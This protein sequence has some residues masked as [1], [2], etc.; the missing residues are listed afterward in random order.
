[1]ATSHGSM[2]LLPKGHEDIKFFLFFVFC[3]WILA[4]VEV[5]TSLVPVY[6]AAQVKCQVQ[7][8]R[9]D[10]CVMIGFQVSN[11]E[12]KLLDVEFA[13]SPTQHS[14][15]FSEIKASLRG[16]G[17][18]CSAFQHLPGSMVSWCWCLLGF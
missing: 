14:C 13:P 11:A 1:M 9:N 16:G 15:R 12:S 7:A 4:G 18:A 17:G 3:F 6:L 5:K 10:V 2:N 8:G